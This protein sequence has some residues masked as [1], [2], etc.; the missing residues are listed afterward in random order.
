MNRVLRHIHLGA[1]V[2]IA[3]A[4]AAPAFATQADWRVR[5]GVDSLLTADALNRLTT[6]WTAFAQEDSSVQEAGRPSPMMAEWSLLMID[7]VYSGSRID[8]MEL[9]IN[10]AEMAA[11]I[12]S[13]AADLRQAGLTAER[14][15]AILVTLLTTCRTFNAASRGNP[16][17]PTPLQAQ[18][19]AFL[20]AH[21]Q[22]F[23]AL[24]SLPKH[25]GLGDCGHMAKALS[26]P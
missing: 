14:Y 3:L 24:F 5:A 1:I 2:L 22:E 25:L 15:H 8:R 6:F 16:T 26:G 21:K 7:T 17:T 20:T 13:V 4:R 11:D 10:M 9:M 23:N 18:N 12:P 19:I